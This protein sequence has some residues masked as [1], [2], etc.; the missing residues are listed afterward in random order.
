MEGKEQTVTK[1]FSN[2][3]LTEFPAKE[4]I[5]ECSTLIFKNNLLTN[6]NNIPV[7]NNLKCLILDDNR[8]KTFEG[9]KKQPKLSDLSIINNPISKEKFL[10]VMSIIIFGDNIRTV[11][12]KQ[13]TDE[14][15]KTAKDLQP[16]LEDF[17]SIGYLLKSIDPIVLENPITKK[18]VLIPQTPKEGKYNSAKSTPKQ[19]KSILKTPKEKADKEKRKEMHSSK[20]IDSPILNVTIPPLIP[21]EEILAKY[22]SKTPRSSSK[23]RQNASDQQWAKIM[24]LKQ[25]AK[26]LTSEESAKT[27]PEEEHSAKDSKSQSSQQEEQIHEDDENA[28]EEIDNNKQEKEKTKNHKRKHHKSKEPELKSVE[29]DCLYDHVKKLQLNKKNPFEGIDGS[30]KKQEPMTLLDF[31]SKQLPLTDFDTSN[32]NLLNFDEEMHAPKKKTRSQNSSPKFNKNHENHKK[33]SM[34]SSHSMSPR[35]HR[36]MSKINSDKFDELSFILPGSE[37][38][39]SMAMHTL[40]LKDQRELFA[41]TNKDTIKT[42]ASPKYNQTVDDSFTVLSLEDSRNSPIH[43]RMPPPKLSYNTM[44]SDDSSSS[45]SIDETH[46]LKT[47]EIYDVFFKHHMNQITTP[48]EADN[49]VA[50]FKSHRYKQ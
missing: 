31:V 12:E 49:F 25:Q 32:D 9:A 13:V 46:E 37:E 34:T 45:Y 27:I 47:E 4:V 30:P 18:T 10:N 19:K 17:I 14:E 16:K 6:F 8:I 29:G 11:N 28:K 1:D 21:Y 44:Y 38:A 23:T 3:Q 2:E 35:S 33:D 43:K 48:D 7:L 39:N 36:S 5:N 42:V 22:L 41:L 40:C 26:E 15:I 20:T 50:H 24:E